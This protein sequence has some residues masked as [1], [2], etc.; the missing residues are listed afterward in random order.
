[1]KADP[2]C[3]SDQPSVTPP[4]G[5][6]E[7]V[8]GA[9]RWNQLRSTPTLTA[10]AT[11]LKLG[12]RW[13][14]DRTRH[15][16]GTR[17]IM[18]NGLV[19]PVT[20]WTWPRRSVWL[21]TDSRRRWRGTTSRP[22][23][24]PTRTPTRVNTCSAGQPMIP[25]RRPTPPWAPVRKAPFYGVALLPTSMGLRINSDAQVLKPQGLPIPGLYAA[26]NEAASV[27]GSEYPGA[28]VQV[29]NALTIGWPGARHSVG[30]RGDGRHPAQHTHVRHQ[31]EVHR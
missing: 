9:T 20:P 12:L 18:G 8:D 28:G 31:T 13:A 7:E 6:V 24:E 1:M 16:R 27:I 30:P 22:R 2:Q 15:H 14:V 17:L 23:P 25:S 19:A 5:T 3:R 29:S 11:A 10:A 26:G 4:D 21:R